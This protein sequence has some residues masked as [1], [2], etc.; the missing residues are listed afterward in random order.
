MEWG[1]LHFACVVVRITLQ[2]STVQY[3]TFHIWSHSSV[4]VLSNHSEEVSSESS[5]YPI[6]VKKIGVRPPP[7]K[8][9]LNL[10]PLN[11]K[12]ES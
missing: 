5:Y 10:H 9:N 8:Y 11:S 1:M 6:F 4:I 7:L 3:S 2:C 12:D